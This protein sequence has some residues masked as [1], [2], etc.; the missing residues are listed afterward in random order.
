MLSVKSG[1]S[2]AFQFMANNVTDW[3]SKHERDVD[4]MA[5]IWTCV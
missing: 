2:G 1:S 4:T 3:S 5:N